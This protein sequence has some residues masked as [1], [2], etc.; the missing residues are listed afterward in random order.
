[1]RYK[2]AIVYKTNN[3][4][5]PD[6]KF[7]KDWRV[8]F[9]NPRYFNAPKFNTDIIVTNRKDIIKA[10]SGLGVEVVGF[11]EDKLLFPVEEK[12]EQK[13][14]RVP[15]TVETSFDLDTFIKENSKEQ[16]DEPELPEGWRELGWLDMRTLAKKYYDDTVRNKEHAIEILEEVEQRQQEA[17]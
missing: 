17:E 6:V 8:S 14:E 2:N 15:E 7:P 3:Q 5:F 13:E 4:A 9:A 1:M 16:S 12:V 11:D 10:Y